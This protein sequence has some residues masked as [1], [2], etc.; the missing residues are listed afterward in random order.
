[1][2]TLRARDGP[3][4]GQQEEV[5]KVDIV[6]RAFVLKKHVRTKYRCRCRRSLQGGRIHNGYVCLGANCGLLLQPAVG[7]IR[8][9][10]AMACSKR[11]E[12]DVLE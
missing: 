9:R 7:A 3:W 11:W 1:M 8:V 5:E 6:R 10:A 2:R 4:T 12:A